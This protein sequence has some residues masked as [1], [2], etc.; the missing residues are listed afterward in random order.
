MSLRSKGTF[1][2]NQ[3]ARNHFEG[4]GHDNAAG[5]KS[6]LSMDETVAKFKDLVA[7]YK[8]ELETSYED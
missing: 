5:G 4:G 8:N 6:L 2:V 1:S 3:F 7:T